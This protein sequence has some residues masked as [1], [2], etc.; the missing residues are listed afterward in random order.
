MSDP[1][2]V[3]LIAFIIRFFYFKTY[4]KTVPKRQ[5]GKKDKHSKKLR[6]LLIEIGMC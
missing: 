5:S 6:E 2:T 3:I 1:S 4:K